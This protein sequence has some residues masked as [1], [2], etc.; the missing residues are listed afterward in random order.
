MVGGNICNF[1]SFGSEIKKE[2]D[3]KEIISNCLPGWG[4]W[5]G[6]GLKPSK[7]KKKLFTIMH[8]TERKDKKKT[9]MVINEKANP[10]IRNH[11]VIKKLIYIIILD[12]L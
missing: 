3:K 11:L 8:K 10:N 6:T 4:E 12:L 9:D 2:D 5:G 7:R 1:L